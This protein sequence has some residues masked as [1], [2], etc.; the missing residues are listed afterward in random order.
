MQ[1]VMAILGHDQEGRPIKVQV[2]DEDLL[3]ASY[4]VWDAIY[5]CLDAIYHC[6]DANY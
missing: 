3:D 1:Q 6:L 5:H 2:L 4:Q